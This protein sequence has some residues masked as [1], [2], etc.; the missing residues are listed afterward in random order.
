MDSAAV[1]G[2]G[3]PSVRGP[4]VK[5]APPPRVRTEAED[6]PRGKDGSTG[7]WREKYKRG[8]AGASSREVTVTKIAEQW[9]NVLSAMTQGM[10]AAGITPLVDP[11]DLYPSI[12]LVVDEILPAHVELTPKM[13]AVGG[14]TALVVQR[15]VRRKEIA[16]A[17]QKDSDREAFRQRNAERRE[18]AEQATEST[19]VPDPGPDPA[20][21]AQADHATRGA[22]PVVDAPATDPVEP[23][24]SNGHRPY[25]GMS[26]REIIAVDPS[27]VI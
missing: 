16:E 5:L 8:A 10:V 15:F 11:A 4:R 18:R 2:A 24:T 13:I 22:D 6:A 19:S 21:A 17:M 23:S 25:Q 12:V 3:G 20:V 7:D 1:G 14:T 27:V 26:A 9:R